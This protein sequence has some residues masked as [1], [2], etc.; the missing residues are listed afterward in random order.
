VLQRRRHAGEGRAGHRLLRV[1][2]PAGCHLRW[3]ENA[4]LR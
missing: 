1:E 2:Q 4:R 3:P